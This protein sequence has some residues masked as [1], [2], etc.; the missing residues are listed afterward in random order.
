MPF[1]VKT[2]RS[3]VHG[4]L[5]GDYI[6]PA[7]QRHFVWK[8]EQIIRLF[9]SLMR[10]YPI[11]SF[12]FWRLKTSTVKDYQFYDF[13]LNYDMRVNTLNKK[14]HPSGE[15]ELVAILDGQQ[16]LTAMLLGLKGS[17]T[18]KRPYVKKTSPNAY[19]TK[20]LYLDLINQT[21]DGGF[22]FSF[23]TEEVA[24]EQDGKIWYRVGRILDEDINDFLLGDSIAQLP[25][26]KRLQAGRMLH[27]LDTVI[28]TK[29]LISYYLEQEQNLD[30]VLNIFIRV[31]SGGTVLTYSDLLFSTAIALWEKYDAR[32]EIE[33]VCEYA[34]TYHLDFGSDLVLKGALMLSDLDLKF[35]T[36]NF[37][38]K[39]MGI[40]ENNW[41]N[42]RASLECAVRLVSSYGY[43][44]ENIS[45]YNALL[46]LA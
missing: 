40:I 12:L 23:L 45:A 38:R 4:I 19:L 11:G 37:N 20:H 32:N 1:E 34:R 14:I 28:N 31:N 7:I 22:N 33:A 9:D 2:I 35:L 8:Q 46:P 42:I 25:K 24:S 6:L 27:R 30:K 15:K 13:I 39:N 43:D 44:S 10:D 5:D 21:E 18:M 29:E 3:M 36:N 16:H 17:Y 26:E 41:E